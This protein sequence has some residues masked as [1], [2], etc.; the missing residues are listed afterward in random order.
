MKYNFEFSILMNNFFIEMWKNIFKLHLGDDVMTEKH[1]EDFY[2]YCLNKTILE[3]K[4]DDI[5]IT[6]TDEIITWLKINVKNM[7]YEMQKTDSLNIDILKS[8]KHFNPNYTL[9]NKNIQNE[10]DAV[11]NMFKKGF[12]Q[13]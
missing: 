13:H 3:F 10:Y 6:L 2:F 4:N 8:F 9:K 1:F 7:F 11:Y 12:F 5:N